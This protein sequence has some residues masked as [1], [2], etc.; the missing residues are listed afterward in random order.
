MLRTVDKSTFANKKDQVMKLLGLEVE[1]YPE[2]VCA[3]VRSV[4][5]VHFCVYNGC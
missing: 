2:L 5:V 4:C 3:V 1:S